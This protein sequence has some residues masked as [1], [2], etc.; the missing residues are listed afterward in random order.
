MRKKLLTTICTL[1]MALA[2]C[3]CGEKEDA[4]KKDVTGTPAV[5]QED[6]GKDD[7]DAADETEDTDISSE[8]VNDEDKEEEKKE[9]VK[10]T[11]GPLYYSE[12][13]YTVEG[14]TF[15]IPHSYR[16]LEAMGWGKDEDKTL[17]PGTVDSYLVWKK[18]TYK[19]GLWLEVANHGTEEISIRDGEV[20]GISIDATGVI[21]K[22]EPYPEVEIAG[23]HLGD[24][25]DEVLATLGTDYIYTFDWGGGSVEYTY[26][27]GN[28][29]KLE[30]NTFQ[31]YGVT[32]IYLNNEI[33]A[34]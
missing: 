23:I 26:D 27:L 17:A 31:D 32:F 30:I 18:P 7:K 2:F 14:T 28:G 13:E 16:D 21:M 5:E 12:F 29:T 6:A 4:G 11:Q 8:D 22:G 34:E 1:A 9:D 10:A 3:A 15:K 25:N 19:A 20:V 33:K 24:S